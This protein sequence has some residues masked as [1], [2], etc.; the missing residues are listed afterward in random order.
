[1]EFW[2]IGSAIVIY[3]LVMTP[4]QY[5]NIAATKKELKESGLTH[6]QTYEEMSFAQ[7]QL[8]LNLQGNLFNLPATLMAQFIYFMRHPGNKR[9]NR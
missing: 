1:M 3:F 9:L 7:Q 5:S 2:I 6:N 8:Q 4:V